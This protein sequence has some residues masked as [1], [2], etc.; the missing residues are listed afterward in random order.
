M[1]TNSRQRYSAILSPNHWHSRNWCLV[2][3]PKETDF[4]LSVALFG[5]EQAQ[6]FNVILV[7]VDGNFPAELLWLFVG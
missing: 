6:K 1:T 2:S 7:Y 3:I 5:F 4:D